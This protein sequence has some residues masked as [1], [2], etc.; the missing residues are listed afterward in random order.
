DF[1]T[2]SGGEYLTHDEYCMTCH[3]DRA[4]H[5]SERPGRNCTSCHAPRK[6]A[7]GAYDIHDHKFRF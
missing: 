5:P 6:T 3:L 7:S 4:D 2:A 1:K